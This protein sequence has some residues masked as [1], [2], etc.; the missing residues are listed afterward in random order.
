[1]SV[2]DKLGKQGPRKLLAIDGGGIRGL[3]LSRSWPRS[4]ASCGRS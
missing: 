4:S 1:M 3:T 2:Q